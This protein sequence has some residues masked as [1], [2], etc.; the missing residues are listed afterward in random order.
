[1]KDRLVSERQ[2]IV[3][4]DLFGPVTRAESDASWAAPRS[5]VRWRGATVTVAS[6]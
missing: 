5:S 6:G 3:D 4:F 2:P 1:M